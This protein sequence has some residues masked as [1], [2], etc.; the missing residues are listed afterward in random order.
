MINYNFFGIGDLV[1]SS[2]H[3]MFIHQLLRSLKPTLQKAIQRK[4]SDR[5]YETTQHVKGPLTWRE[6]CKDAGKG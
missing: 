2:S 6:F 1:H 4:R 3:H 5:S